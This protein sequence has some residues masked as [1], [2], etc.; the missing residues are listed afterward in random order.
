MIMCVLEVLSFVFREGVT[1]L[2]FP[3][4]QQTFYPFLPAAKQLQ[5]YDYS[6]GNDYQVNEITDKAIIN[7]SF[8]AGYLDI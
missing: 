6:K 5:V 8:S 2:V 1:R 4:L 7:L 3:S